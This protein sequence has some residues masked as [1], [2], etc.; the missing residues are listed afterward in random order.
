MNCTLFLAL[1]NITE[2][3]ESL[4]CNKKFAICSQFEKQLKKI[5]MKL[6]DEKCRIFVEDAN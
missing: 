1:K 2:E 6:Q 4:H 5:W 3:Q